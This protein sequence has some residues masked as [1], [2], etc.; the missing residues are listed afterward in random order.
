MFPK[1]SKRYYLI[2]FILIVFTLNRV[3]IANQYSS[4]TIKVNSLLLKAKTALDSNRFSESYKAAKTALIISSLNN[5]DSRSAKSLLLIGQV[6]SASGFDDSSIVTYR[7][8]LELFEKTNNQFEIG[9]V[10]SNI[11]SSYLNIGNYDSSEY[12]YNKAL[13]VKKRI[14]DQKGIVSAINNLGAIFY[15]KGL[16]TKAL[17]YY[18]NALS[19]IDPSKDK[20]LLSSTLNNIGGVFWNQGDYQK[21][22]DYFHKSLKIK[23]E[24]GD[25]KSVALINNN[26]G[27]V[28]RK[29]GDYEMALKHFNISLQNN[30]AINDSVGISAALLGI[31]DNYH[32]KGDFAKALE[33]Y[34]KSEEIRK[35]LPNQFGLAHV[36]FSMGILYRDMG[37]FGKSLKKFEDAQIIYQRLKEPYGNSNSFIQL[38]LTYSQMGL[39]QKAIDNSNSGVEIAE[40]IGALSLIEE[41]YSSLNKI[42]E[43][44]G[45][46]RQAYNYYKKTVYYRD[47]LLNIEKK[48]QL[49]KL[50]LQQELEKVLQ[51]QKEDQDGILSSVQD[52]SV[53]Q[54]RIANFFILAFAFTSSIIIILIISYR[55][56]ERHNNLLAFQKMDME[57]Q[58]NE[59]TGQRDELEIQKNLVIHQRDK[60]ITMLTELGESI[61]Y[62]R[63]IQQA[64]LPSDNYLES[65]LGNYFL[66]FNPRESVGGDFYWVSQNDNITYFAVGDCTGHGVPGGFMSMLGVSLLNEV[67]SR[68]NSGTPAK[69][70]WNLRDMIIKALNQTG[71][72]EDS[73]DGM[74]I[75]FCAYNTNDN[76]LTFA[77][78]NLSLIAV[79][80]EKVYSNER[81]YIHDNLVEFR[82]D[83]MPV[84]FYQR[85]DEYIEHKIQLHSGDTLYLFSDGFADQFGGPHNKKYGYTVF[86]NLLASVSKKPFDKQRDLLWN[87]F[88]KWKGEE[89]QT[90]DVLVMGIRIP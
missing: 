52:K 17:E 85:M 65:I 55:Q 66:L 59:L 69:I 32:I 37:D 11:G 49:S 20:N 8:S 88:D 40:Q 3:A 25:T 23:E 9:N 90:D 89:N 58:K 33:S 34:L 53:K 75:A 6:Q 4:D 48:N 68:T 21:A 45:D 77:G 51:K 70:L 54:T 80:S 28:Y 74:D 72:D 67:V 15:H 57:R 19:L 16:Y 63:K 50:Q 81:V 12:Y 30:N 18:F 61:D 82:P 10:L 76:T 84:S 29:K 87:E 64:L 24:I 44:K 71:K 14:S 39:L 56:K 73:Q 79:I 5:D 47:S 62:A 78:A 27:L 2:V 1:T 43:Q 46:I 38:G 60:I 83:R 86:R 42:Y 35:K 36:Y 13:I 7:R 41:G 31:G 22:L 26:I